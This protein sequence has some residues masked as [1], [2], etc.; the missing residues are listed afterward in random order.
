MIRINNNS[1]DPHFNLALEEYVLKALNP[2]E[3]YVILWQNKPSIIIGKNQNAIEE[4]NQKYVK[5]NCIPVVRRLSGGGAV[6]H[7][8]GNLNFTFIVHNNKKDVSNYR[9]FTEPVI[10]ALN[11]MGVPAE[12]SGRNDI[13][14]EGKKFSGNAQYYYRDRLLHHGTLLYNSELTRL[15]EALNVRMD[16][17]TSKGIKSVRSRVTN[18]ADY[19]EEVYDIKDFK[20]LLLN[21]I[22]EGFNSLGKE[23]VLNEVDYKNINDI[24]NSRYSTWEWNYGLSPDFNIQKSRRFEGG[25][26]DVRFD[27]SRGTIEKMKIFGDFLSRRDIAE[28]VDKIIGLKYEETEIFEALKDYEL[29][30]YLGSIN[31]EDLIKL[32]D[33]KPPRILVDTLLWVDAMIVLIKH[34]NEESK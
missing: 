25:L 12:F 22:Q 20:E 15:G 33:K 27:V 19:L 5:D 6:Y 1:N 7:D 13:T 24:M 10:K 28:L 9:K 3:D 4:I 17:I 31:L 29:R 14:I 8:F 23:H 2:R 26:L 32:F 16:K 30:D 18:I 21:K 11:E 34:N